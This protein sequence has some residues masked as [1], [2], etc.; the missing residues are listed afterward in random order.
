[1]MRPVLLLALLA[2]V[3]TA[4]QTYD[5]ER[6]I[7]LAVAQ[8]TDKTIVASKRLKPNVMLLVDNSGSML[9]PTNSSSPNCPS[10]CGTASNPCPGNC[11]TRVSEMKSAMATFFQTSP[12]LARFG[13]SKFPTD[14]QCA[15]A[16][17]IDVSLPTPSA[18]DTGTDQSL[19]ATSNQ[20]NAF[21][22]TLVPAGGTP[23]GA[24]LNFL[25][26]Y[27][28]INDASDFRD[29]FIL[30]LTD[31]LPNCSDAN[32]NGLCSC[33]ASCSQTQIQTCA[34]TLTG[35][36]ACAGTGS[37]C[38]KGCLDQSGSVAAVK[39][40]K[41]RGIRTIVVGFGADL[42][43][44]D[45]PTVLN[46]MA[47]EGGFARECPNGTDA[48]CGGTAGSCNTTTKQCS[49]AFFQAA[50]GTEL[51]AALR[52]ISESFQGDPCVFTLS[53]RPSDPRY[54]SVVIDNQSVASSSTTWTF[55]ANSN[56]VTFVGDL[57]TRL[58]TSTTQNPVNVEF[59][60]VERF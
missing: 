25:G 12:T 45:G 37:F 11:P 50:N 23:T 35:A 28:G 30:L 14:Q 39:A 58:S 43:G 33:G 18:T 10:G 41:Q 59:R 5:F 9:L 55:D 49:T 22:Q 36:N 1:M 4:C 48:E 47:K 56:K 46:A 16:T 29:D 15:A 44:G 40:L 42:A 34:C 20:V 31:G 52:K 54:L 3:A 38:A 7:P 27:G 17:N 60:I 57:C 2:L 26:T 53:S 13:I 19:T 24:S 51:A 21:I 6:V 8:T 32:P